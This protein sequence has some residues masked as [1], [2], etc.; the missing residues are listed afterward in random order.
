KAFRRHRPHAFSSL[1]GPVLRRRTSNPVDDSSVF[2][3]ELNKSRIIIFRV[4]R[5]H[6]ARGAIVVARGS[7]ESK[8]DRIEYSRFARSRCSGNEEQPMVYCREVEALA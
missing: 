5:T 1:F 3:L 6:L 7:E 8:F 2:E 4:R